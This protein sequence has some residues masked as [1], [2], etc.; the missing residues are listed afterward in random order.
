MTFVMWG[1]GDKAWVYSGDV[2]VSVAYLEG[3]IWKQRWY[4]PE[5]DI[6]PP[7]EL[8]RLRPRIVEKVSAQ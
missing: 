2:G 8:V 7:A 6:E 4:G 5:K 3:S 1:E